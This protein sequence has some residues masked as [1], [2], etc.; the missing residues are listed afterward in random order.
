[1]KYARTLPPDIL[2]S[3]YHPFVPCMHGNRLFFQPVPDSTVDINAL[4]G[5]RGHD[6]DQ[7]FRIRSIDPDC[8]KRYRNHVG[9]PRRSDSYRCFGYRL[10]DTVLVRFIVNR[11]LLQIY[12]H[13]TG[14]LYVSL[15]DSPLHDRH[16]HCAVIN[17][18]FTESAGI[19]SH[20]PHAIR[21]AL[22]SKGGARVLTSSGTN[23]FQAQ[24]RSRAPEGVKRSRCPPTHIGL[25]N[26][27]ESALR[28]AQHLQ[29]RQEG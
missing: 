29:C 5:R 15:L 3:M 8:K 27:N 9:E 18:F 28:Y 1:M 23:S 26:Q 6:H 11:C 10:S 20:S 25:F 7:K 17:L 21:F 16:Y 24:C 22:Q 2:L 12:V 14:N 4:P 19:F 13:P